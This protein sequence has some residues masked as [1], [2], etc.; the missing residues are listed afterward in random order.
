MK[1][2][3]RSSPRRRVAL[4]GVLLMV[5]MPLTGVLLAGKPMQPYLA[6]PPRTRFVLHPPFHTGVFIAVLLLAVAV[7]APWLWRT[8]RCLRTCPR[9]AAAPRHR[10]PW[11]GWAGFALGAVAWVLAWSRFPWFAP[12]Q[13]HTFFPLWL[14]L[15]LVVNA[16]TLRRSGTCMLTRHPA[17]YLALFPLSAVFWWVFE[18]INRFVQNWYYAGVENQSALAYTL[19]ATISF[20]TVLP[21]VTAVEEWLRGFP[22]LYEGWKGFPEWPVRPRRWILQAGVLLGCAGLLCLPLWPGELFPLVWISPL[23]VLVCL[24]A[25]DGQPTL[26][27]PL[28]TGD[29]RQIGRFALASLICGFFWELWNLYSLAKWIYIIPYVHA[30]QLFEMPVLGYAGY[31]PFGLLCALVA[32]WVWGPFDPEAPAPPPAVRRQHRRGPVIR[33]ALSLVLATCIWMPLL[34]LFFRPAP[35]HIHAP[36]IPPMALEMAPRHLALWTDEPLRAGEQGLMR[37]SNAEW[38]FMGRTFLALALANMSLHA[39]ESAQDYLATLDN[40]IGD[41]LAQEEAFGAY[42][43]L[44]DY[45]RYRPFLG[46]DGRSI[47]L[48]GEIALMLGARRLVEDRADYRTL[49]GERVAW[50]VAQLEEGPVLSGESYPDECWMF[51]NSVA[52]VT[53]RMHEVLDGADHADLIGRWSAAMK[54]HLTDPVSGILVSSFTWNGVPEDGPEG[55]SIWMVAHCLQVIDPAWAQDQ[56]RRARQQLGR[57]LLGFGYAREWP[58]HWRGVTDIDSGPVLPV[59]DISAG[60]S[61][62]AILGAAAFGDHR[63]LRALLTSLQFGGFPLRRDG[64]LS[65]QAS[66]QVGDA[67]ILYALVQGP[68]WRTIQERTSP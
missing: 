34:H 40:I 58:D 9:P 43:F 32:G 27:D 14:A 39:P 33:A 16:D 10:F 24:Q 25:L 23:L 1:N 8:I 26:L 61:G 38:D 56:Y 49:F 55:S 67:V 42:H 37:R 51:C 2:Q 64:G 35:D 17:R 52:I 62:M 30:F 46:A 47:F 48:D 7:I 29:G 63:W 66:N 53:L 15:I 57:T 36:G 41:T 28:R 22:R 31:L 20:S 54:A 44:M 50:I 11:W 12:L 13:P 19:F 6:F 18:F 59:L 60:S 4:T 3:T 68:L 21:A 45:A 5:L 65:F